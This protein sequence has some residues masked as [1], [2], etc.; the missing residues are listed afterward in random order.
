MGS[1]ISSLREEMRQSISEEKYQTAQ[2]M[3]Q[4]GLKLDDVVKVTGLLVEEI[5]KLT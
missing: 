2:K 1:F 3:L 4:L 5:K